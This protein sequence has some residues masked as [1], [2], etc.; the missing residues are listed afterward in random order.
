LNIGIALFGRFAI[1]F[2]VIRN[3]RRGIAF[4]RCCFRNLLLN[5][6]IL[7][8]KLIS[9]NYKRVRAFIRFC[10]CSGFVSVNG[11]AVYRLAWFRYRPETEPPVYFG[12]LDAPVRPRRDTIL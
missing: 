3:L 2:F 7:F 1:P 10:I 6:M 5:I 11:A 12:P 4:R 8:S 9:Y